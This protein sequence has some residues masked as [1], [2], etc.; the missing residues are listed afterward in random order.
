[1]QTSVLEAQI[2]KWSACPD[3]GLVHVCWPGA[4]ALALLPGG[5]QPARHTLFIAANQ[6]LHSAGGMM[7]LF[8]WKEAKCTATFYSSASRTQAWHEYLL[9]SSFAWVTGH[10]LSHFDELTGR[11]LLDALIRE[12]NFTAAARGWNISLAPGSVTDQMV[13]GSAQ[14]AVQVYRQLIE[15]ILSYMGS[16]LGPEALKPLMQESIMRLQP[17][18]RRVFQE[19]LDFFEPAG[20]LPVNISQSA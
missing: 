17:S 9:H 8:G 3:A 7:A 13:F 18:Y 20:L 6:I 1:M 19:S 15:S 5:S 14:E 4:E 10:L 12:T 16:I 2:E 11:L